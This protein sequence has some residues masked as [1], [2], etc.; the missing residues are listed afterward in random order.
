MPAEPMCKQKLNE[1]S[2]R[3]PRAFG[4]EVLLLRWDI[5]RL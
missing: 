5:G 3:W 2:W 4:N 1:W